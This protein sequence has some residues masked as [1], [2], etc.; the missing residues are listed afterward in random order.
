M[1]GLILKLYTNQGTAAGVTVTREGHPEVRGRFYAVETLMNPDGPI[2]AGT[3]EWRL[4]ANVRDRRQAKRMARRALNECRVER[5]DARLTRLIERL[6][7]REL[8]G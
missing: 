5:E 7:M 6:D 1:R 4:V 8:R 3:G 2:P